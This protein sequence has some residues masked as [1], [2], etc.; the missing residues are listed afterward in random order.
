[1]EKRLETRGIDGVVR[2]RL[3]IDDVGQFSVVGG[4][5]RMDAVAEASERVD[6]RPKMEEFPQPQIENAGR[7]G[8]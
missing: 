2:C 6:A 8:A 3:A 7:F 5:G 1:M 4:R